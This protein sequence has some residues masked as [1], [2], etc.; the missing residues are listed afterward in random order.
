MEKVNFQNLGYFKEYYI[1]GKYIGSISCEIG[2][3]S[4]G[5]DGRLNEWVTEKVRLDNN[6][7]IKKD[8]LVTTIIYPLCGKS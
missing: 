1:D 4:I 3:R 5:Y 2:E 7:V 6:R 8:T